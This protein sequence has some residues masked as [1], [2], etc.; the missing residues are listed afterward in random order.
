M[1]SWLM[2]PP[3]KN[4]KEERAARCIIIKRLNLKFFLAYT[5]RTKDQINYALHILVLCILID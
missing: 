4:R 5:I 3:I 1:G 2:S